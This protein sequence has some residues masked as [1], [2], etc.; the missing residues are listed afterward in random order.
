MPLISPKEQINSLLPRFYNIAGA[1]NNATNQLV[2]AQR[3][4]LDAIDIA[5]KVGQEAYKGTI[6]NNLGL[7]YLHIESWD[8]ALE[9]IKSAAD[10]SKASRSR[11]QSARATDSVSQRSACL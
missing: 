2:D 5:N 3:Y 1:L 8:R 4:F 6:Y 9:F 10:L 11:A 7:L